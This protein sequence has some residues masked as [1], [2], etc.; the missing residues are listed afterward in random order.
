MTSL[1]PVQMGIVKR[2]LK[3]DTP[4]SIKDLA[5]CLDTTPRVIRYRLEELDAWLSEQNLRLTRIPGAGLA[6]RLSDREREAL[7]KNLNQQQTPFLSSEKRVQII[8]FDL[9]FQQ[10]PI[11]IKQLQKQLGTSRT[12]V[13]SDFIKVSAWLAYY[14]IVLEKRQNYGCFIQGSEANIRQAMVS[15]LVETIGETEL[16]TFL[17]NVGDVKSAHASAGVIDAAFLQYLN[18][19]DV[20]FF[21]HLIDQIQTMTHRKYTDRAYLLLVLQFAVSVSRIKNGTGV[22]IPTADIEFLRSKPDFHLSVTLIENIKRQLGVDF[23]EAEVAYLMAQIMDAELKRP[24]ANP[25]LAQDMGIEDRQDVLAALDILLEHAALYLHPALRLDDDLKVSLY[26]HLSSLF[27]GHW[28]KKTT[29]DPLIEDVKCLYPDVYKVANDCLAEIDQKAGIKIAHDEIGYITMYLVAG[30]ERLRM[31]SKNKKKALIVCNSGLAT[32][33]LLVSRVIAEFPE[34]DI[35]GIM[36]YLEYKKQKY[37]FDYDLILS[38]IPIPIWDKPAIIVS[39]LLDR[40]DVNRIRTLLNTAEG[41]GTGKNAAQMGTNK[42]AALS[43]LLSAD[44]IALQVEAKSWQEVIDTAGS[45]LVRTGGVKPGYVDAMKRIRETYGPYMVIMPGVAILHAFPEDGVNRLCMSMVTLKT[46]VAFGNEKFDPV[47]VAFAL[48]SIDNQM[49]LRALSEL[50]DLVKD[51]EFSGSLKKTC[52]S[53]RALSLISRV[54]RGKS[55]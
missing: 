15:L 2:L 55:G 17:G 43:D 54:S 45:L 13:F 25:A 20:Q 12:T 8:L 6:L 32:S 46:P 37:V 44:T 7:E 41:G 40:D 50:I 18:T 10:N 33:R 3:T 27:D 53:A 16:L 48:G 49:H 23:S 35:T 52:L 21:Y 26:A 31:L 19:L 14:Q 24:F 28:N 36:S 34:I 22:E 51:E 42:Q 30:M 38:S 39:P 1:D 11:A 9:F 29:P 4:V 5:A 47:Q